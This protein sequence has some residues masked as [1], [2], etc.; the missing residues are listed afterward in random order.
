MMVRL[1]AAPRLLTALWAGAIVLITLLVYWPAREAGFVGDDF[2]ILHRLRGLSTF[3]EA[4]RFFRGEFFEYYRPLGFLSQAL[5]WSIAGQDAR[6]FHMTNLVL[7]G[8]NVVLVLLIARALESPVRTSTAGPVAALLFALHAANHETVVWVSARFDLLATCW[9]LAAVWWMVARATGSR[10]APGVL[11]LPAVLSKESTVALPIAAAA[12]SVFSLRSTTGE[13]VR[14]VAPW[15][16]VLVGYALLRQLAGGLPPAGGAARAPK[17]MMFAA[18]LGFLI[19]CADERWL[20]LRAWLVKH[21]RPIIFVLGCASI[22]IVLAG[23]ADGS[24]GAM[25]REKLAVAGFALIYL[26]APVAEVGTGAEYLQPLETIY[27]KAALAGI[28]AVA[29]TVWTLRHRLITDDRAWFLAALLVAT[30]LP[31]SALT[32][33]RRYLYLPSAIVSV[34]FGLGVAHLRDGWRLIAMAA[35]I[36]LLAVSSWRIAVEVQDWRWAGEMTAE[37][38]RLVDETLAPACNAGHVVF[39]TS[40]VGL[41]G[42]YTHFYYETFELPRGCTPETFHVVA[43]LLRVD[44]HVTAQWIDA[45]RIVLSVPDYRGNFVL[46]R[47]LRQFDLP[48]RETR[49]RIVHTPLGELRAEPAGSNQHLTLTLSSATRR[50]LP[51]FFYYSDGRIHR[52]PERPPSDDAR[53]PWRARSVLF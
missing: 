46:S 17:L 15:L 30:L 25:A 36:S 13:T 24:A 44:T 22:G 38:A 37:G 16:I 27:W 53:V 26:V 8:I 2:M 31:I 1:P 19:A 32:E 43:R 28:P 45:N 12:W 41:R 18:A 4:L 33:G 21:A 10:W 7:H 20:C 51:L 49:I 39:L 5:D 40:P 42:V 23:L 29:L 50:D 35:V 6:Q 34:A 3:S 11:F 52:L 9:S 14:R 47:D 48:L